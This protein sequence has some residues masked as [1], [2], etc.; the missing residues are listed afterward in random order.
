M[1]GSALPR[2][3]RLVQQGG[4]DSSRALDGAQYFIPDQLPL[5]MTMA[6]DFRLDRNLLMFTFGVCLLTVLAFGLVPAIHAARADLVPALKD[7]GA[8]GTRFRRSR[9][10]SA[11]VVAQVAAS[12]VLLIA[13]GLFVRGL[14]QV[15]AIDPGFGHGHTLAVALD[16][17]RH[18][19]ESRAGLAFCD[20]LL[21]RVR[22]MPDVQSAAFEATVPIGFTS[23]RTSMWIEGD[24]ATDEDGS[25]VPEPYT[26]LLAWVRGGGMVRR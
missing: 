17:G 15:R 4:R 10:R 19:Y 13:S 7:E 24:T 5:N 26:Q 12:L 2:C 8:G 20:A 3:P 25:P 6:L 14:L 16:F 23:H 11:L 1:C 18:G 21:A 22:A 9:L